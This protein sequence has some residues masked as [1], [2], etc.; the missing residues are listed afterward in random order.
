MGM[1]VDEGVASSER[2]ILKELNEFC[3]EEGSIIEAV[4]V[5]AFTA[6]LS[7]S[8]KKVRA[9]NE[10]CSWPLGQDEETLEA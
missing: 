10:S 1:E 4:S 9:G 2:R 3:L 6:P 8:R 7:Q 5:W